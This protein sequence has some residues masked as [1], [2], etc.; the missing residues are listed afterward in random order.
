MPGKVRNEGSEGTGGV[1]EDVDSTGE[2]EELLTVT[3]SSSSS[4]STQSQH[5][6][7]TSSQGVVDDDDGGLGVWEHQGEGEPD[8]TGAREGGG[9]GLGGG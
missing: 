2:N 4:W 7:F 3:S 1:V 5:C 9:V 6:K 8:V